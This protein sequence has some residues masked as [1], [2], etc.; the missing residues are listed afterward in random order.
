MYNIFRIAAVVVP[1]LPRWL[2]PALAN[3][4][5][6]AAWLIARKARKQVTANMV[7]V[8]GPAVLS[9]RAG[10]GRLRRTVRGVFQNSP[11]NYL[12]MFSL[13]YT[14]PEW[15]AS[16]MDIEGVEHLEAALALGRGVILFS[17]HFGPIDYLAQWFS[18]RGYQ[19]TI[20]V[21]RLKD[22]RILDLI[23]KLRS[24]QG[25]HFIPLG[26]STAV[27]S[28]ILA[29]RNNQLVVIMAD[30]AIEG[31]SVEKP[32]F[33]EPARLPIGP[34]SLSQRTGAPLVGAFGWHA[35]SKR[36]GGHFVPL[37]LELTEE[38]RANPDTLMRALIERMEQYIKAHPEQWVVF[39]PIWATDLAKTS[40]S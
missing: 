6:F 38:E 12:E 24:S 4:F 29:L 19:M 39:A 8:L 14:P 30:R 2:V 11:R 40:T 5:G 10:R 13:P 35:S 21:E 15:I 34:V 3:A 32:F 27:R 37:S 33:G 1:R 28:I 18:A 36:V 22:Q 20:P 9:T 25:I 16:H 17:A 31:E 7:H 23:T 26:D